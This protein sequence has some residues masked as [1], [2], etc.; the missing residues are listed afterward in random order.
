MLDKIISLFGL[1]LIS[2]IILF[3][4]LLIIIV[5]KQNPIFIQERVGKNK[6]MFD[7]IKLR[8]M[9]NNKPTNL[10][11]ILRKYKIDEFP[12]FINVILGNMTLI[13]PRP[14][15]VQE[16]TD[17]SY[18]IRTTILPG[19]TGLHQVEII[20]QIEINDMEKKIKYDKYYI[21]NKSLKLDIYILFKTI[22]VLFTGTN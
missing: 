8:T 18:Y 5:D 7:I 19:L 11:A 13:G 6:K 9:K 16:Y 4:M 14:L 20:D 12:Q 10:G 17:E 1:I 2:P 22:K 21:D 15:I 3:S